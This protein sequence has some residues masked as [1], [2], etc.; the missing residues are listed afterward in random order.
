MKLKSLKGLASGIQV[1]VFALLLLGMTL[2]PGGVS[3]ANEFP[4]RA[5]YPDSPYISTEDLAKEFDNCLIFDVRSEFEFDVIH[6][7]GAI[8]AAVANVTFVDQVKKAV[9][10]NH[11]KKIVFYCNG[12]TCAKSYKA[13]EKAR[14]AGVEG[15]AYDSGV[16]EWVKAHPA[17]SSLLGQSPADPGKI[18][19]KADLQKKE[20]ALDDF[21]AKAS[22]PD[23]FLIDAR[24][25]IQRKQTPDWAKKAAKQPMDKLA[26]NLNNAVFQKQIEGKT[27]YI[28]DAVGKQ[29]RWLQ[30][31]LENEGIKNYYFLKGGM[32]SVYGEK[33]AN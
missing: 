11:G 2:I 12:H 15:F 8:N 23:A 31:H 5:N 28:V 16:F 17:L 7:K 1:L 26:K 3:A 10:E 24:D 20:L 25:V 29:V 32:W 18:I 33:G 30:Y 19:P 22:S 21:I 27:L 14:K 13:E 4:L 9:A 6:I